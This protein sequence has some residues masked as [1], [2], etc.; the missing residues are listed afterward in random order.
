MSSERHSW[1]GSVWQ[2]LPAAI[3]EFP[4]MTAGEQHETFH[5]RVRIE[6]LDDAPADFRTPWR[7]RGRGR[8]LPHP[9]LTPSYASFIVHNTEKLVCGLEDQV[10]VYETHGA[11]A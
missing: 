3:A 6:S 11:R 5:G 10:R 4:L 9:I 1:F 7:S 2:H 8:H